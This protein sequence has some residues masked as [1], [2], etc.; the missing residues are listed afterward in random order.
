MSALK[1]RLFDLEEGF[2]EGDA[3]FYRLNADENCLVA[4]PGMVDVLDN[5]ALAGTVKEDSRWKDVSF[6]AE[7]LLCPTPGVAVIAYEASARKEGGEP[8]R[9]SVSSGYIER[10]GK[11]K[12]AWHHHAPLS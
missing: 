7:K 1:E 5:E 4:F 8:Q 10:D 6:S 3:E 2:W 9:S 11:W 12:L